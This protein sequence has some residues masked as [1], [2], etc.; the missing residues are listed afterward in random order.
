M[1]FSRKTAI[2]IGGGT[3]IGAATARLLHQEG[4]NVI[5]GGRRAGVLA[6]VVSELDGSGKTA[7]SLAID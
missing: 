2:V 3:G 1:R 7:T 4:A 6:A 5:V